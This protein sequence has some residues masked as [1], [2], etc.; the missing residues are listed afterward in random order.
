MGIHA[1]LRAFGARGGVD[2]CRTRGGGGL[3]SQT[4][5][6]SLIGF[7]LRL[8]HFS[9]SSLSSGKLYCQRR[10]VSHQSVDQRL[11]SIYASL[12]TLR[13]GSSVNQSLTRGGSLGSQT[14][15]LGLG[16]RLGLRHLRGTKSGLRSSKVCRGS[17]VV[18]GQ[19]IY[20]SLVSRYALCGASGAHGGIDKS[21]TRGC[22]C[23]CGIRIRLCHLHGAKGG[24]RSGKN[25]HGSRAVSRQSVDQCLVCIHA[26]LR[27]VGAGSSGVDKSLARGRGCGCGIGF[28]LRHLHRTKCS[29]RS[30]KDRPQSS[31][32]QPSRRVDQCLMRVDAS[33]GSFGAVC[34]SFFQRLRGGQAWAWRWRFRVRH[35]GGAHCYHRMPR[36]RM[37][38][39]QRPRASSGFCM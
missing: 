19:G 10:I 35:H 11:V 14:L 7:S 29:L 9:Q 1:S 13:A 31:S 39:R 24:L 16:V 28:R 34:S 37:P 18:S 25:S 27:A 6:F 23:G 32:R 12:R 26:S 17:R 30:G 38:A 5:G 4:L 15:A 21:L 36:G 20:E 8:L 33:L 2:Q 22:G 3:V